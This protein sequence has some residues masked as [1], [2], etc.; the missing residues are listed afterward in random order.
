[1]RTIKKHNSRSVK[2]RKYKGTISNSQNNY[3][4]RN[5]PTKAHRGIPVTKKLRRYRIT[6]TYY[7]KEKLPV[8]K[9]M[10]KRIISNTDSL[11]WHER[12]NLWNYEP[13]NVRVLELD[14]NACCFCCIATLI[15]GLTFLFTSLT[16]VN[17]CDLQHVTR[18]AQTL[19]YHPKRH[20]G[21]HF[22]YTTPQ[23]HIVTL[24]CILIL[25]CSC[26]WWHWN[27]KQDK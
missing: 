9:N 10:A 7:K 4:Y 18:V 14:M 11:T 24:S 21:R 12:M 1:M 19:R 23:G 17:A 26:R 15:A 3:E 20:W 5:E 22:K 25:F 6:R 8:M 16:S 27:M 13:M 2:K